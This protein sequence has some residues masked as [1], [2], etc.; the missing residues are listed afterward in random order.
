MMFVN[1]EQDVIQQL[2]YVVLCPFATSSGLAEVFSFCL[3]VKR[4]HVG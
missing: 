1:T 3:I 2:S 4:V